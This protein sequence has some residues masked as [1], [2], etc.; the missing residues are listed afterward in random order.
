MD[1]MKMCYDERYEK[2]VWNMENSNKIVHK[3]ESVYHVSKL[4]K[5]MVTWLWLYDY[6]RKWGKLSLAG[7]CGHKALHYNKTVKNSSYL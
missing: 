2:I 1:F 3:Q 6:K 7:S 4:D 5:Y